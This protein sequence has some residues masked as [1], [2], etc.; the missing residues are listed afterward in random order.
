MAVVALL[1]KKQQAETASALPSNAPSP[2]D[3]DGRLRVQCW[4]CEKSIECRGFDPCAIILVT[5]WADEESQ[6]KQQF[7][8]H[9]DCF[10][11]SGS[12]SDLYALEPD[13]DED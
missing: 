9:A 11:K 1:R 3:E 13:F 4:Y 8:A 2:I 7:F 10:R 6:R 5:N 12:G